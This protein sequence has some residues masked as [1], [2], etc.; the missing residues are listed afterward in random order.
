MRT[1][2]V[3]QPFAS[4]LVHGVKRFEARSWSLPARGWYLIH[5]SQRRDVGLTE[6]II[7]YPIVRRRIRAAVRK[8]GL[9]P[10]EWPTSALVGAVFFANDRPVTPAVVAKLAA[11]DDV[12]IGFAETGLLWHATEWHAFDRSIPVAGR[13]GIWS[14]PRAVCN[15]ASAQLPAHVPASLFSPQK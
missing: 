13:L 12:L 14:P 3:R 5:A 7:G 15:A 4:L 9:D 6:A 11:A 1:L 8:T 10:D 2:S